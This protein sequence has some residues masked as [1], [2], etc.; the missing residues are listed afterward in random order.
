ME[1]IFTQILS[2][3]NEATGKEFTV[4]LEEDA[5]VLVYRTFSSL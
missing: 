4:I 5:R 3:L 1:N 2:T